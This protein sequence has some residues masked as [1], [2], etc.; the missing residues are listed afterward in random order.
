MLL[1]L[2]SYGQLRAQAFKSLTKEDGLMDNS[3]SAFYQDANGLMY[4]GSFRG[5]DRFD[6]SNIVNIPFEIQ[7][8]TEVNYV[9]AIAGEDSRHLLVGNAVGLWR[10][11]KRKLSL[12]R[13]YQKEIDCGV[14][15]IYSKPSRTGKQKR[16]L[17]IATQYG[18]YTLSDGELSKVSNRQSSLTNCWSHAPVNWGRFKSSGS[19]YRSPLDGTQWIGYNFFGLDYTLV[20]RGV[21]HIWQIPGT[22]DSR[23][24]GV[25]NFLHDGSRMFI[26]TRDGLFM[27]DANTHVYRV[28]DINCKGQTLVTQVLRAGNEYLVATIGQGV[29]RLQASSL[30]PCGSLLAGARVYQL[31]TD[32][33]SRVWI[34]SSLGLACYNPNDRKLTVYN[35]RNSQLPSDEVFCIGFDATGTGWVSTADGLCQYR[36]DT[37]SITVNRLSN[38]IKHLSLMRTIKPLSGSRMLF[39]PQHGDPVIYNCSADQLK[40]VPL[41]IEPDNDAVLYLKILGS[42]TYIFATSDGIYAQQGN[43]L[44][45]FSYIDGL[46]N[47]QFQSHGITTDAHGY[48]WASTNGGL[49]YARISDLLHTH[50]SH[51]DIQLTQIQTDH[52]F[53]QP[54]VTAVMTDRELSLGRYRS[55]FTVQFTPVIY[56]N[57]ADIHYRYRLLHSSDT[58]WKQAGHEHII[59]FRNLPAGNYTLVIQAVGMPEISTSI[60]I[61]V[62][63]TY[64]AIGWALF[65]LILL[66]FT[67]YL[68]YCHHFNKPYF[69]KQW[70]PKPV[71]YQHSTLTEANARQLQKRLLKVMQDD[72]PYLDSNL[73]MNDLAKAVG[74]SSHELSQIFSQYLHRNYYDFIAEYRVNEFKRKAQQPQ[75]AK[76]TI[77]ALSELCGFKSRTPFLTAFKRFTGMTPREYIDK[78][79]SNH[80]APTTNRNS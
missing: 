40:T 75:Y 13:V 25:R 39:I 33:H 72:K 48:L 18:V 35:T 29:R 76:Y 53:T 38:K 20:N 79:H 68:L 8:N 30:S 46:S 51:H 34:C 77:V 10:L 43:R 23:Q 52:W 45:S 31:I 49:Y 80:P 6:G 63:F 41:Q 59:F 27:Y 62:P 56:G 26:C 66:T 15:A 61:V 37:K 78:L 32:G 67:G 22:V 65:F 12:K 9:T 3:I 73:I 60:G 16:T 58:T 7:N 44:R 5:I 14:T 42:S 64:S 11:D 2:N 28:V 21:F 74:C 55:D 69:W 71:K 70:Q 54:E 57:T 19:Y 4:L 47:K 36:P 17:W 24:M 1:L 50:F